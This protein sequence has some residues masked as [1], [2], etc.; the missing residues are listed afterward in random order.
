[1]SRVLDLLFEMNQS[2]QFPTDKRVELAMTPP[3]EQHEY[4]LLDVDQ[5]QASSS[6]KPTRSLEELIKEVPHTNYTQAK[7]HLPALVADLEPF[8]GEAHP[9]SFLTADDIDDYLYEMDKRIDEEHMLP[10]LA[11]SARPNTNSNLATSSHSIALRNP[12]SVYNW[13]RKHAPKTFLQDAEQATTGD[14][15]DAHNEDTPADAKRKRRSG[16]GAGATK[17][18]GGRGSRGG[19]RR[20]A[21][22]R[23]SVQ[24]AHDT[25]DASMDDDHD[26]SV[27]TPAPSAR[28]GKRK[29]DDD[30]GYR[31]KGGSSA[32]PSKKKRKSIGGDGEVTTPTATRGGGRR[33]RGRLSEGPRAKAEKADD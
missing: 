17:E 6:N 2:Q 12:T 24:A 18:R 19:K 33:G 20:A 27:S 13:L 9:P 7:E 31:P 11:P 29:R 14:K 4:P 8:E 16:V 25:V 10:T 15:D 5:P 22:D 3:A 28:G 1:M 26:H 21:A 30:A 32:R 23:A